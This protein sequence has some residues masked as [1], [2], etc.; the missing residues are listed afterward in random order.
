MD[1]YEFENEGTTG[2]TLDRARRHS[3]EEIARALSIPVSY[4][5]TTLLHNEP[6]GIIL[7]NNFCRDQGLTI[8]RLMKYA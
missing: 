3:I 4:M 1:R 7:I 6:V 8:P 2:G 5:E